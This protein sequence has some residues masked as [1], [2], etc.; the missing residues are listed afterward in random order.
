MTDLVNGLGGSA[1]FGESF[2]ADF[3]NSGP[4]PGTDDGSTS[5]INLT[6]VFGN[7]GINFFGHYYTGLYVNN[8]GSVTF[9]FATPTFT[10]SA[11]TGA[12]NNPI[13][14]PFWADVDT[15]GGA[16][17][18]TPGG[19][20]TG[21]NLLWYDLDTTTNTFTATWDDV[22]YYGSHTNKLNA[23][24]LSLHEI[25][26]Q[27]DFDITFRYEDINWTTG[28]A[29]GGSNGLGGTVARAGYSA[30]NGT[31]FFELSQSG[32]QANMLGLESASNVGT[33]GTFVFQVRNGSP[34]ASISVGDASI[35]EGNSGTQFVSVP[36]VL[37]LPS[38]N[39][40][41]VHYA[42]GDGS[43]HAGQD[44]TAESGTLTFAPGTT[45][46]NI[47]IPIIGDTMVEPDEAFTV[48]LSN[49]SAGSTIVRNVGTVTILN[50]DASLSI[51]ATDADKAEGSSGS[52]NFI[53]TVTRSGDS[54]TAVSADWAVSGPAVNGADFQ[55]GVL[56][57]GTVTFGVGETS[58]TI[59]I[60]VAGDTL[61]ESDEAFTVTLSD[62]SPGAV[63]GTAT[64]TGIIRN[65]DN[66][67]PP[68]LSIAATD[69]DKAEG[70]SGATPFTFTVTR[71]GDLS[72]TSSVDWAVSGPPADAADFEGGILPSGTLSFAAG[73]DTMTITVEIAGDTAVE[74]DEGF[75]VIL[76]NA[77]GANI[78]VAS[79]QGTILNDDASLSISAASA[80]K[81]EG[82]AGSTAFT[83]TVTRTG[84]SATM[85][86]ADWAVS[87]AAVD[88]ADFQ[89]GTLPS[90]IVT[91]GVGETSKTITINVAGDLEVENDEPFTVTLSDPSVGAVIGTASASGV[92]RNDDADLSI[93]ATDADK[94]EGNSGATPF[95]FTVTRTG[96]LSGAASVDWAV[97]GASGDEGVHPA[98]RSGATA[99]AA[100]FVGDAL[101][102]GT[103][104][105]AS[106]EAS[107][108]ITVNVAGDT[109]V[110]SDEGFTV[111]LSNAV[112]ANISVGS[113]QGT[114]VNDDAS[115]SIAATSADKME[116]DNGAT[117]FTFTVTRTGDTE[118]ALTADW[119]VSGD[120]ING[121]DFL[122][123]AGLLPAAGFFS[124]L[125]SFLG[126]FFPDFSIFQDLPSGQV[127]F[128]AGETSKTITVYALG[129]RLVEDN[130]SFTVT[131]SNPSDGAIIDG[132]S[133]TGTIRNDDTA[134]PGGS[135]GPV[136]SWQGAAVTPGQFGAWAPVAVTPGG[137]GLEVAWRLGSSNLYS[138]WNTDLAGNMLSNPT[139]VVSGSS[140][141]LQ[142]LEPIFRQDINGDG[143]IGL[144]TTTIEQA[145]STALVQV[146]DTYALGGPS[147]PS[148]KFN[149]APVTAGQF[150]GWAPIAAEAIAGG[151]QVAWKAGADQYAV[152]NTDANG[153]ML[154][155]PTGVVSEA[156]YALQALEGSFHQDLNGD[157]T[158]GLLTTPIESSGSTALVQVAN[159]YALGGPSGP[160]I[161]FDGAAVTAGQ[162][163][164]WAPIAAEAVDGGY[165]VAWKMGADQYAV[166]NTDANGNMLTS[167]TGVVSGASYAL[168]SLE[169]GFQQD[170]NGDG[171]IGPVKTLIEAFGLTALVQV[172]DTYALGGTSGPQIKFNGVAVTTGRFGAWV[173]FAAEQ[174]AGGGYEVAWQIVGADQYAVWNTDA[175]GN[176]LTSPT[177][178]VSGSTS[179]LQSL[180]PS[181]QQDLNGDGTIGL[182]TTVLE[183]FGLIKL[184]QTGDAY[185]LTP[186]AGGSGPQIRFNGAVVTASRFGAWVPF[187]A[188]QIAG[189]GYEVAW[190]IVGADQYAVWNTDANG[191]MLTSPTGVVSGSTST[192]QALEPSFHQD[193]NGDGN[194]GSDATMQLLGQAVASSLV[195]DSGQSVNLAI[196]APIAEPDNL[197]KP[198]A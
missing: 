115:L 52:T 171:M 140:Y 90:G 190:Q 73:Q 129:D 147:G 151:Y 28:D 137:G 124:L 96:D 130:E 57:S 21:S 69:A 167:P 40:I 168:Q 182:V 44:Y 34:T 51:A 162:F 48:T 37:T 14:A 166:W 97:G 143:T 164:A 198:N 46:Q 110:E 128:A 66:P 50:D 156:S 62:P 93:A 170:L 191:N 94:A 74:G 79:A 9:N 196:T 22:G 24:Q 181:F 195:A 194:I 26:T 85:V 145:G 132:A 23:F 133:A 117:A 7:Q 178:V 18:R 188:E 38:S 146:A 160:S 87:G 135:S 123:D 56:P 150:G 113:A 187:A 184:S 78:S 163:G 120:E 27:G 35:V 173:P 125:S 82:D 12:T 75:A 102:S 61:V 126:H 197:A 142:A 127:S 148:I 169:F 174:I 1:G 15:R 11:I 193:L 154:T 112:G 19:T 68:D 58:K 47:L 81:A 92:I 185:S 13:I 131:L 89:G 4:Y 5:F 80:D 16:V 98:V 71:S 183:S 64:A 25:N 20:S 43:A 114:I 161:K 116:G 65:D 175:N 104:N 189:G 157:G 139:G 153:N 84:D 141:A 42:T 109:Q 72:G 31:N 32:N 60:H 83:F 10:P 59:T 63:I 186:V 192:L 180:E 88:G 39:T 106:G 159:I 121:S 55:G 53:F 118:S 2:L 77:V 105:F 108:T 76:S 179:T 45:Q 8:N 152:W 41:T 119:T 155:S 165:E 33:P 177:G 49:P 172:A 122:P 29:S 111:T 176:M 6:S 30:G 54:A 158:I 17:S 67:P 95:T 134:P 103:I 3:P 91:F 101:P 70:N 36:V 136:L 99:D 107:K 100:D 86:S 144:R 138:V 149:G